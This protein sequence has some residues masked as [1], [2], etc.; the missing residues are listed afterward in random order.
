MVRIQKY[1][2]KQEGGIRQEPDTSS[3]ASGGQSNN[4]GY[5]GRSFNN[6]NEIMTL[7]M[8]GRQDVEGNRGEGKLQKSKLEGQK[9]FI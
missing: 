9:P 8:T 1:C 3:E 6:A 2:Q 7:G 5:S 4:R